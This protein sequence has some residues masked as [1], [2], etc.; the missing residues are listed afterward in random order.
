MDF[1]QNSSFHRRQSRTSKSSAERCAE[2]AAT[3]TSLRDVINQIE[4]IWRKIRFFCVTTSRKM[5]KNLR[6]FKRRCLRKWVK[7]SDPKLEPYRMK[8]SATSGAIT[9]Q[10][11]IPTTQKEFLELMKSM[12][13]NVLTAHERAVIATV[14]TFPMRTVQ[15]IMLPKTEITYVDE[16]EVLG[17]LTLDRLYRSGFAHFPVINRHKEIIGVIHT[18]ALNSLEVREASKASDILDPKVCYLRDDYTLNQALAAFYRTNCYFFLVV[19]PFERIV[20]L[21]T[22]QMLADFLLGEAPRDDFDRDNDRVAVARR[23]A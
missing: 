5:Q 3:N 10:L 11:H 18:E 12:P 9:A 21:L 14:M 1:A 16:D 4:V 2:G 13:K 6:G 7:W 17:P 22:Y 23:K 19:D 15:E 8:S 20:G